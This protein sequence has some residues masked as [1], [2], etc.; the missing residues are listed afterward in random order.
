MVSYDSV[1]RFWLLPAAMFLWLKI[2][3]SLVSVT[4][5]AS[6]GRRGQKAT[7][8]AVTALEKAG[9]RMS[10]DVESAEDPR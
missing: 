5:K 3:V 9:M 6:R 2:F 4:V 10:G 8:Q 7:D 1:A